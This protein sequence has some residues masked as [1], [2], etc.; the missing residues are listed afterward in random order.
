[1]ASVAVACFVIVWLAGSLLAATA[2]SCAAQAPGSLAR[3][4][5]QGR[6]HQWKDAEETYRLF[7]STHT[8]SVPAALG[9]AE[10]LLHL[11]FAVEAEEEVRKLLASN[12]A[13]PAV[14]KLQAWL[15]GNIDKEP[16]AAEQALKKVTD[17]A[18]NDA[19]GWRLLGTFYLDS[20][21]IEE[22]IH[23]FER[24]IALNSKEPLY[25]A[26]LARAYA[27]AGRA[28][29]A[30]QAFRTAL[31][32][33]GANAEASI[34]LW[35]GDFLADAQRHDESIAA[36]SRAIALDDGD[37][38]AWI[39]R[40][41]VQIK[42]GRYRD[43]ERDVLEARKRGATERQAENLL[44]RVYRGLGD[45]RQAQAAA[46]AVERAATDEEERRT[47][48]RRA[49]LA[50]EEAERLIQEGRFADALPLYR[51]VSED[52]PNYADAWLALGIC[53]VRAGDT[54]RAEQSLRRFVRLQPLSPDGHSALGMLLISERKTSEARTELNE[55]LRLDPGSTE[56]KEALAAISGHE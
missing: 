45:D 56:A 39:Q 42:A 47:K 37:Y 29:E 43:A 17:I 16:G 32:A 9:H 24:A 8:R 52:V 27:A 1:M 49:R 35:Y 14:Y 7:L 41:G 3:A 44:V 23:C 13:E 28:Q 22:S 25:R 4:A 12:P 54:R 19:D 18:P 48:W 51:N 53:Y 33:A 10:A 15:L 5:C 38:Q 36:Y 34:F 50:L 55:A 40:A 21:R 26:G 6:L 2:V 20:H 31:S 11:G 46:A 30:A